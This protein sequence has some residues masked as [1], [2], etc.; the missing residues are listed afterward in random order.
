MATV[1]LGGKPGFWRKELK[2]ERA[3]VVRVFPYQLGAK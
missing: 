3:V 1:P 2:D